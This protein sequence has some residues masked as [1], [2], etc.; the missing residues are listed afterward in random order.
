[1]L[2]MFLIFQ[3]LGTLNYA[4][5]ASRA[6][7][8]AIAVLPQSTVTVIALPSSSARWGKS[9][10]Q[11]L[12]LHIWLPDAMEGPTPASARI[13]AATTT[14]GVLLV[15]VYVRVVERG[16]RCGVGRCDHR[17]L[18]GHVV[19]NDIKRVLA[20]FTTSQLGYMFLAVVSACTAWRCST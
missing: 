1:M 2:A 6:C 7:A 17:A 20:Y 8:K 9:A 13:H 16:H 5:P 4:A 14:A 3:K 19:Q 11:L 18:C 10:P 15:R 12:P